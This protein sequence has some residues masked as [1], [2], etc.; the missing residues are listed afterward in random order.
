VYPQTQRT[1]RK[2]SSEERIGKTWE[3]RTGGRAAHG[4]VIAYLV[5]NGVQIRNVKMY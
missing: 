2:F 3:T 5:E 1:D 4:R